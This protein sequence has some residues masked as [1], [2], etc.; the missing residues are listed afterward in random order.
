MIYT[1]GA[2][3]VLSS[4]LPSGNQKKFIEKATIML[5]RRAS[6][7]KALSSSITDN[8]IGKITLN[9]QSTYADRARPLTN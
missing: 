2:V 7:W 5:E 1:A 6:Q 4:M 3:A 9:E 8:L